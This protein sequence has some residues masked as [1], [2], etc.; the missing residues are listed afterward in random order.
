MEGVVV[1]TKKGAQRGRREDK[2]GESE[3]RREGEIR[4]C[5]GARDCAEVCVCRWC[6]FNLAVWRGGG[7]MGVQSAPLRGEMTRPA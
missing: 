4:R 3:E 1:G 2:A 7:L 6:A 5:V